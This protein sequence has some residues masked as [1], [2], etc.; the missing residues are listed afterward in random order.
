MI[1]NVNFN[2]KFEYV[3]TLSGNSTYTSDNSS[4]LFTSWFTIRDQSYNGFY[5]EGQLDFMVK[6][7]DD[8]KNYDFD[9]DNYTYVVT[10]GHELKKISY[11]YSQMKNRK[12]LFIPKQFVGNVILDKNNTDNIYIYRIKKMDIDYDYH[13]RNRGV[14]F[15]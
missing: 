10:V 13:D 11:S 9:Y 7:K 4:S 15:S 12:F 3:G 6:S 14:S 2:L 8:L 1:Y 5:D